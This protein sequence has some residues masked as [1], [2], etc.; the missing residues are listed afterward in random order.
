MNSSASNNKRKLVIMLSRFPFPLDK[1]DKLRAYYQIIEF[2]KDFDITLICTTD[3]KILKSEIEE[4]RPYCKEIH[5][6]KLSYIS[7]FFNLI[8]NLF[9]NKP[10]QVGYFYSN[11]NSLYIKSI[12]KE[13]QPDHIF[14]QLIRVAEYVKNYHDCPK[15]IDYMDALSKGIERRIDN[16][17]FLKKWLFKSEYKRL[18]NYEQKIYEYFE[19]HIIISEQDRSFIMHPEYLKIKCIPNGVGKHFFESIDVKPD[20]ELVFVGNLSY[21]PNISAVTYIVKEILPLLRKD[22]RLI[23]SGSSPHHSLEKLIKDN[24]NITLTGWV[25]DIRNSYLRGKL[26]IA[27]MFIGTGLQNKLIES[28]ALGVPC[29]TT[30]LAN[31]ALK[32]KP[33][34]Q[35]LVANTKEEFAHAITKLLNDEQLYKELK[36]NG[37]VFVQE[38]FDWSKTVQDTIQLMN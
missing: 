7:I 17:T 37:K 16:A 27:P 26:F 28:M 29:I 13:V 24:S 1:G 34:N 18:R 11:K 20:H 32:A 2:S 12:L 25:D 30:P 21:P 35:I 38:T 3:K 19:H 36:S 9:N 33:N 14:C 22:I 10:F 4:I 6:I 5:I 15:T 8:L 31:N 23:V